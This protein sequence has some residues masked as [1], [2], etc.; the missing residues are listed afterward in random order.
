MCWSFLRIYHTFLFKERKISI[1]K[2][3][4]IVC[5]NREQNFESV[6]PEMDLKVSKIHYIHIVNQ[7]L[8]YFCGRTKWFHF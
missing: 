8:N 6:L 4:G 7:K 5:N 3:F 1:V 2:K